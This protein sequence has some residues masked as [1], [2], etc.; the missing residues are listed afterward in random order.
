MVPGARRGA[1]PATL[2]EALR[3]GVRASLRRRRER[4]LQPAHPHSGL[5]S[6]SRVTGTGGT[7]ALPSPTKAAGSSPDRKLTRAFK[8]N[9][10]VAK[11]WPMIVNALLLSSMPGAADPCRTGVFRPAD[12]ENAVIVTKRDSDDY[13]FTFLDGRRGVVGGEDSPV[14]CARGGEVVRVRGA[15]GT[16]R[17]W[18]RVPLVETPASFT[19]L[20]AKFAARLIEP[21]TTD[22]NRPLV[23]VLHGSERTSAFGSPYPYILAAQ[24]VS[25]FLYDKRGTGASE[26]DYT[27]NFELLASDAA[28]ASREARRLAAGRFGRWGFFG[29]SQGG[30]IAP[31]AAKATEADFVAVGFGLVMSPLEEDREQVLAELKRMGYGPRAWAAAREVT[32]ATGALI[33]SHFR[34]G[35][36]R[37]A[38]VKRR[39]AGVAWLAQINGEF[40]GPILR[41]DPAEL[42][43]TGAA[44]LD[45]L[46]II[47]RYDAERVVRSLQMPQLWV[48]AGSDREA[49][50]TVTC[51]RLAALIR[52]GKPID[53]FVFP[54]TDHG[55]T[56]YVEAPDGSRRTTRV[57]DGY[58]RLLGDWIRGTLHPPYGRAE[59]AA[60]DHRPKRL[61]PAGRETPTV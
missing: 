29:G 36:Q 11:H 44:R 59:R 47:W 60:E 22:P 27:Q 34:S 41:A 5:V 35:Y 8:C 6:K 18:A 37:L 33:A 48:L 10:R 43:R 26:G 55:I 52:R 19:N 50:G 12:S 16:V 57:A 25:V 9:D 46:G 20:D 28:A 39:D 4:S 45:G 31:L 3:A 61:R 30:W 49:P 21:A 54:N 58:Y 14:E 40:T 1:L 32:D 38:E 42:R 13:R 51:Q 56:E 23:V 2:R 53:L 7:P 17:E 24:G 15:D